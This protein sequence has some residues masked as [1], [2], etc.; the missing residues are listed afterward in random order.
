M[1]PAVA[2][3]AADK[4]ERVVRLYAGTWSMVFDLQSRRAY[5]TEVLPTVP[6]ILP[7]IATKGRKSWTLEKRYSHEERSSTIFSNLYAGKR[8]AKVIAKLLAKLSLTSSG[9]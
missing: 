4:I 7:L 6:N 1:I 3:T 8:A 2:V 5:A 9:Q